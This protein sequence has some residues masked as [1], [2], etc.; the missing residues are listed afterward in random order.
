LLS[1]ALLLAI[2]M[3]LA[4]L[5][6]K[7]RSSNTS[8]NGAVC[9]KKTG[10]LIV[11]FFATLP[12]V[13][14]SGLRSRHND[15]GTYVDT[16]ARLSLESLAG[17]I[18]L[19]ISNYP[20]YHAT[21][22]VLK[23]FGVGSQEYLLVTSFFYIFTAFYFY[24]KNADRFSD[25]VFFF[26]ATGLFSFGM[27]GLKQ[28]IGIGF[29]LVALHFFLRKKYG[30]SFAWMLMAGL[31]HPFV[32]VLALLPV[33]SFPIWRL[34][35]I[36]LLFTFMVLALIYGFATSHIENVLRSI[37]LDYSDD[38]LYGAASI[39]PL[40]V[41]FFAIVPTASFFLRKKINRNNDP[42]TNIA[43]NSSIIVFAAL[44]P[45]LFSGAN[46]FGRMAYNFIPLHVIAASWIC[47]YGF[48]RGDAL[49]PVLFKLLYLF[50]FAYMVRD[51]GLFFAFFV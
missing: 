22:Y 47:L 42:L 25:A 50:F 40:R 30:L 51:T 14:F 34:R 27:A 4:V 31:F 19:D 2:S 39:N 38:I 26:I 46:M 24:Y 23:L 7:H 48:K 21:I 17:L 43:F 45:A 35:S 12:M 37:G 11:I 18:S 44:L 32:Y 3:L 36:L 8:F 10:S 5:V 13:L 41:A 15:T 9:E 6:G 1:Y 20:A 16:Y 28:S 49:S 33:L 29:S